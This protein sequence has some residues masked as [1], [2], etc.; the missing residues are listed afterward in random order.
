MRKLL[1]ALMMAA[2]GVACVFGG[3]R[4]KYIFLFIGDG[5]STPQRMVGEEFVRACRN[6]EICFNHFPHQATTRTCSA[7]SLVTDSA[8]AATAIA[9]GA[10]TNNGAIGVDANGVRLVSA[11]EVARDNGY[12]VGIV[13]SV[14]IN[15]ATPAG[16]YGH[17]ASRGQSYDLGL[18]LV[19]SNFDYFGGGSCDGAYKDGAPSIYELAAKAGYKVVVGKEGL[20]SVQAGDSKVFARCGGGALPYELDYDGSKPRL[21]EYVEKGIELLQDAENGFFM[22]VEGGSIDWVGHSN[23]AATNMNELMGLDKAVRVALAFY[24]KHK[25]ETLIV[26]TGDHE[27]GGMSIG[28]AGTGYAFYP[29][30]LDYQKCSIGRFNEMV[31]KLKADKPDATFDD[32]KE[33]IVKYF[34]FKFEGKERMSLSE[35]D[36]KTLT[37]AFANNRLGDACRILISNKAGV[38]WTSGSHTALPV[39][40]T[41][42]GVG[43]EEFSGMIENT[44]I[45]RKLKALMTQDAD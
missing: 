24:E 7:N 2:F 37:E 6:S 20:A 41:S 3:E 26:V 31:K 25:D 22:M 35:A 17:R 16:F 29:E 19:A 8:A 23:D 27:T 14:T 36:I 9:C 30:V 21:Y 45:S 28:F 1:V 42:I 39:L 34:G 13:S 10:K 40:T 15:H 33:L 38:G 4:P 44:D 11:A 43:S 12:K 32:A 18:D 5:M